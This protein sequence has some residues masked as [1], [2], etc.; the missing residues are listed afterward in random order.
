MDKPINPP[1]DSEVVFYVD[2]IKGYPTGSKYL[3]RAEGLE[4][5]CSYFTKLVLVKKVTNEADLVTSE[6]DLETLKEQ[7]KTQLSQEES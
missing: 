3:Y 2:D 7:M 1:K 6:A 4:T 5:G